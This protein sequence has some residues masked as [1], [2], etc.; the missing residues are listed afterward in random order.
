VRSPT[1]RRIKRS[2]LA[3]VAGILR[4]FQYAAR[5][6]LVAYADRGLVPAEQWP[7]FEARER[8]WQMWVTAGYL[9]G[10]LEL[11]EG[12]PLV[13]ADRGD[14]HALLTAYTLDKAL[15][16]VRYDL[17]HRPAWAP[18]PLRGIVQLLEGRVGP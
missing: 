13:P 14:L 5:A 2:G 4:S 7:A 18:I 1:E 16:E 11:A 15:Y 17:G 3:D 10:Y 8:A 9:A 6:G 12:T